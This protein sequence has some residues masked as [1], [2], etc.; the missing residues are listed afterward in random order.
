MG[1]SPSPRH[2]AVVARTIQKV[3][4]PARDPLST[5]E[6]QIGLS[7]FRGLGVYEHPSD[8]KKEGHAHH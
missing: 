1:P 6:S 8:S 3:E 2:Q 4:A 7:N 5:K